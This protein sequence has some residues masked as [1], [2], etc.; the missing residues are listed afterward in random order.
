MGYRSK[1]M[2][3]GAVD[4]LAL[5]GGSISKAQDIL[6]SKFPNH[7]LSRPDKFISYWV[8]AWNQRQSMDS[9]P[10][11]GRPHAMSDEQA[12][13]C[14][15]LFKLGRNIRG[16]RRHFTS[17]DQAVQHSPGLQ[18]ALEATPISNR[19]LLKRMRQVDPGI[20]R[21]VE[22]V[23]PA[24]RAAL[25][26]ERRET[27]AFMLRQPA[28]YFKRIHWLDMKQMWIA[29]KRQLVWTDA[30]WGAPTVEDHRVALNSGKLVRLKFY[31]SV[32]WATGAA[33]LKFVTGTSP[34]AVKIKAY[35]VSSANLSL[36]IFAASSVHMRWAKGSLLALRASK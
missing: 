3:K 6:A 18:A 8:R 5:A 35:K 19:T 27:S 28:A 29:P 15:T 26:Q 16:Q 24:L 17:I 31:A 21:R 22:T 30:A 1:V 2:R 4:A 25:K 36:V 12:L 13:L 10:K 23:K 33:S 14:A 34:K 20:V 7:G 32:C 9:L 11:S